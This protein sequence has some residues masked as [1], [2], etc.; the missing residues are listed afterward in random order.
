L[1]MG[2][3]LPRTPT[4]DASHEIQQVAGRWPAFI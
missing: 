2:Y 1:Y 3:M 4:T